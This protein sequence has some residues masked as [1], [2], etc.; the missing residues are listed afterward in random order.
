MASP[1][2]AGQPTRW[3]SVVDELAFLRFMLPRETVQLAGRHL[4]LETLRDLL[5]K[6][7][8][9]RLRLG[10]YPA[11]VSDPLAVV[12]AREHPPWG[13]PAELDPSR[14]VRFSGPPRVSILMVT[15]GNLDLTRLCLGSVQRA[16]GTT[17]FELI[18]VDNR[19]PDETPSYLRSVEASGLLPISVLCNRDNRGF[20]AANNQAA[21]RARGEVLVLLN[22]DTI[23][24]PGWLERLVAVLDE[25]EAVGMVGPRTNSCGNEAAL[26]THYATVAEMFRFAADYTHRHGGQRLTPDMLTLFCAAIRTR[27][28]NEVGGL[29][30]G[31]GLGMFEDDDLTMAVRRC[32]HKVVLCEDAFVHHYGGAAFGKLPPRQYLRLFWKNRRFFERKWQTEWKKR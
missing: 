2:G 25:D 21:Q 3:Q 4:P 23:V 10:L 7:V 5:P 30:E 19:S 8:T 17:P 6:V 29:D 31:Y 27:V 15:Y 13:Q 32:R 1:P 12:C 22:N 14:P 16:A 28:W 26:G 9:E 20:A 24:T 18:V 11:R